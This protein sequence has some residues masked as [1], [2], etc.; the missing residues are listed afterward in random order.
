MSPKKKSAAKKSP[1]RRGGARP[2]AKG[3]GAGGL[4]V[5]P[6][7]QDLRARI[8]DV[9]SMIFSLLSERAGL[10]KVVG[11]AKKENGGPI[12][13]PER[14]RRILDRLLAE[15]P[16]L[17]SRPAV[18]S[19][20]R[21]IFSVC[22]ALEK[23]LRI[24]YLGPEGTFC[25]QAA[26]K[27]FGRQPE[28]VAFE[29]LSEVVAAAEKEAVDYAVVP[30]ENSSEGAINETMDALLESRSRICAEVV[31]PVRHQFLRA[32]GAPGR[33]ERI[34]AHPQA[35]AQCRG[36][37]KNNFAQTEIV[38]AT[39]NSRAAQLA[40]DDPS[41]A[42]IGTKLAAESLGLEI[43][44]GDIQ[45]RADNQTR[46]V[47]LGRQ[48]TDPS[49][50][51]KTSLVLQVKDEPGVLYKILAPLAAAKVSLTGIE[52]RPAR[53]R[54]WEY[55]FYVDVAGHAADP[56]LAGPLKEIERRCNFFKILG[57]YPRA[58][59]EGALAEKA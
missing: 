6:T 23:P 37:L 16:G 53:G 19:V 5:N 45:D 55:L 52:S 29:P 17:L 3:P 50:N 25:H 14:E 39:S 24:A 56:R 22:L 1:A 33:V 54:P 49:G 4:P 51:D 13:V 26:R 44:A 47:V 40:K 15:N 38:P 28:F 32:R 12:H 35:Q 58:L 21:E 57:A 41:S 31:V 43:A 36:W 59:D 48:E 30:I 34:Y 42:A 10:V 18:E 11:Q 8:D 2:A 20:F 9:D 7:I 27:H 46:F